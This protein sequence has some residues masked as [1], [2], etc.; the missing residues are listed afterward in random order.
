MTA[1]SLTLQTC[2][3]HLKQEIVRSVISIQR[4]FRVGLAFSKP[5][6]IRGVVWNSSAPA[7]QGSWERIKHAEARNRSDPHM[8]LISRSKTQTFAKQKKTS[9]MSLLFSAW[10]KC[11]DAREPL[12]SWH[13]LEYWKFCLLTWDWICRA[14]VAQFPEIRTNQTRSALIS[15]IVRNWPKLT[16]KNIRHPLQFLK[17]WCWV[18]VALASPE[19]QLNLWTSEESIEAANNEACP[20][21]KWKQCVWN[22]ESM[23][24]EKNK[25]DSESFEFWP[26]HIET[27][28]HDANDVITGHDISW[29]KRLMRWTSFFM[30]SDESK[31]RYSRSLIR[32]GVWLE[33][34]PRLFARVHTLFSSLFVL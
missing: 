24:T 19:C 31:R 16:K 14:K 11:C 7:S 18:F 9:A 15:R 1:H 6:S 17:F 10:S 30:K 32:G 3:K 29:G 20:I 33:D 22:N 25:R 4:S 28:Q 23:K 5:L 12:L 27:I 13:W 26:E 8:S 21:V 2:L 34:S